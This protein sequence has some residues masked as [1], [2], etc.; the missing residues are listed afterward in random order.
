ML[1]G[2]RATTHWGY[3][4]LFRARYPKVDLQ[5]EPLITEDGPICCSGGGMA[6]FDLALYLIERYAGHETAV[7]T[8]KS[9]VID[10]GRHSQ[11]AYS[12]LEGRRYHQ[13]PLV[14]RAQDWL[15]GHYGEPL[16]LQ[17]LASTLNVSARTL[18]RRF[19]QATGSTALSYQQTLRIEAA[20]RHLEGT[21]WSI[22][23]IT[24]RIGYEDVSSFIRLFKR[25][26]GLSPGE[27]R[28]RFNRR[29]GRVP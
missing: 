18:M 15:E 24:E 13:D 2:R 8:A 6:W 4:D 23:Q 16:A 9:Y 12:A 17:D 1:D 25:E 27:Y 19:R 29:P 7:A 10:M 21:S 3:I 11:K 26:T 14:L 22:A 28:E 20:R 5:P